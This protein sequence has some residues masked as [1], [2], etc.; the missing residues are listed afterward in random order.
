MENCIPRFSHHAH[1]AGSSNTKVRPDGS[2]GR[3]LNDFVVKGRISTPN[4]LRLL[5]RFSIGLH[6]VTGDLSQFYYSCKL[7]EE[8]WNLQRFLFREGL[9]PDGQLLEGV[10]GALIYGVKC[11]SAQTECAIEK[12]ATVVENEHPELA[13]FLRQC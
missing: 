13:T 6:A 10:I 1:Q 11:V 12:I 4:L 2:G 9:N 7:R 3:N 8:Q 5:L